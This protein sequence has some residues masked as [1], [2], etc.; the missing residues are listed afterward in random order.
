MGFPFFTP[1][2][3]KGAKLEVY[4]PVSFEDDSL[5]SVVGGQLQYRYFP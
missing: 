1:I 2:Y 4:G 5:D 3:I